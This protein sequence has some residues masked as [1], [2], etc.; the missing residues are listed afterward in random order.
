MQR[1]G[2]INHTKVKLSKDYVILPANIDQ[3]NSSAETNIISTELN[4][5]KK[6]YQNE[7][8]RISCVASGYIWKADSTINRQQ[9]PLKS[10]MSNRKY[11]SNHSM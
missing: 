2:T 4:K 10:R 11:L 9:A 8:K 3:T 7:Y 1:K 5:H 6:I